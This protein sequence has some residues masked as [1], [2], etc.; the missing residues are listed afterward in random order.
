MGLDGLAGH[1][2][3]VD[4]GQVGGGDPRVVVV[5]KGGVEEIA[6]P[7]DP[8]AHRAG[9]GGFRPGA[10]AGLPVRRD[11]AR[12]DGAERGLHR[13]AA[14]IGRPVDAGMADGAIADRGQLRPARDQGGIESGG[15]LDRVDRRTPHDRPGDAH[16]HDR[17]AG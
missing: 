11:V 1:Q 17:E 4:R 15:W 3:G 6:S 9:E 10:D 5:G 2:E 13:F 7:I 14:G 16:A 8:V 12:V